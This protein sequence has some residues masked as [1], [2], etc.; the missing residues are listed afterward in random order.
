[1]SLLFMIY[2]VLLERAGAT[3]GKLILGLRVANLENARRSIWRVLLR[4]VAK[5]ILLAVVAITVFTGIY[6]ELLTVSIQ[7]PT[8]EQIQQQ[9]YVALLLAVLFLYA[10]VS[11]RIGRAPAVLHDFF[12]R[13]RVVGRNALRPARLPPSAAVV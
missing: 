9:F 4:N 8:T 7:P 5:L 13:T 10:Y 2:F 6:S 12:C 1:L 11:I 3:L